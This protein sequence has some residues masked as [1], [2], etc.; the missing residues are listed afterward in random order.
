FVD[1]VPGD[2]E[3]SQ[4]PADFYPTDGSAMIPAD[5]TLGGFELERVL[6]EAYPLLKDINPAELGIVISTLAHGADGLGPTVNRTLVNSA[7]GAAVFAKHDAD[8]KQFLADL[9]T[10]TTE[11]GNRSDD[12]VGLANAL[13]VALPPINERS[14]ELN[15]LLVQTGRLSTDAA[16]LLEANTPF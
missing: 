12:L 11:L 6:A 1:L 3:Y 4:D 16:D 13:N 14:A 2:D 9:A 15:A 8:T 10:I 7:A 5:K